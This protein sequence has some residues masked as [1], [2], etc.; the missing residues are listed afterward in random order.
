MTRTAFESTT[1]TTVTIAGK[2]LT[3][4]AGC[5]YLGLSH[6][7]EVLAAA[8]SFGASLGSG[9]SLQTSGRHI[10]H[11]RLEEA[12]AE[13]LGVDAVLLMPDGYI[14]NMAALQGLAEQGSPIALLDSA[15][16]VSLAD[17]ARAAGLRMQTYGAGDCSLARSL[18]ATH[19]DTGFVLLTDG[20]FPTQARIPALEEL[21]DIALTGHLL[22]DESHCLGV[23][24][25][26]GR[27]VAF[28]LHGAHVVRT[29]SLGKALGGSGGFVAGSV[30][31]IEKVRTYGRAYG[32]STAMAP[33]MA[34]ALRA[35]LAILQA[36]PERPARALTNA[37]RLHALLDAHFGG[38]TAHHLPVRALN[39]PEGNQLAN[40]LREH[41]VFVPHTCYPGDPLGGV[42][43]FAVSSEH[44]DREFEALARALGDMQ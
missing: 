3:A 4:F 8:H 38:E 2:E 1:A 34:C 20:A 13:F 16:H 5:D 33:A 31:A 24:G 30:D 35:S 14:A 27:G 7:P 6:H 17:A 28:G 40:D 10:V 26:G 12:L 9:A 44:G 39:V 21:C 19:A 15:A 11:D 43:R 23:L 37:A 18:C 42:V 32:G 29:S 22:V 36:E 41:G 25:E